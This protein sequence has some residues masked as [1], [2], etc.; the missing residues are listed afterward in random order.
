MNSVDA[1]TLEIVNAMTGT[2]G[3]IKVGTGTL[4]LNA[5]NTYVGDTVINQGT[6]IVGQQASLGSGAVTLQ[7]ETTLET[8]ANLDNILQLTGDNNSS[9]ATDT[10]NLVLHKVK[11]Y[12]FSGG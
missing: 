11:V 8:A 5:A 1:S 4:K 2:G 3:F 7:A 12:A 6:V 9:T 10:V